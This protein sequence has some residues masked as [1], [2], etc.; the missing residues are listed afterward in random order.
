MVETDGRM[1]L[2]VLG[3][4]LPKNESTSVGNDT[5]RGQTSLTMKG[6]NN[7][8]KCGSTFNKDPQVADYKDGHE[9]LELMLGE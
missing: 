5:T 3:Q 2:R 1:E 7:S 8:L 4:Q 9:V 6:L